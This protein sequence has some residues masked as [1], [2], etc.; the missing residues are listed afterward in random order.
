[1]DATWI[2]DALVGHDTLGVAVDREVRLRLD[3]PEGHL[4]DRVLVPETAG[5]R[6][7]LTDPDA[8]PLRR[9]IRELFGL[10]DEVGGRC[11]LRVLTFSTSTTGFYANIA[12]SRMQV[13]QVPRGN[14]DSLR[15]RDEIGLM[16]RLIGDG[17]GKVRVPA[18]F[19]SVPRT[20]SGAVALDLSP[21]TSAA[22]RVL[23][24]D[25]TPTHTPSVYPPHDAPIEAATSL[26][27]ILLHEGL[28]TVAPLTE[29]D[30]N[31]MAAPIPNTNIEVAWLEE[32]IVD[33]LSSWPGVITATGRSLG[34]AVDEQPH[35]DW[36]QRDH[37]YSVFNATLRA[38]L[39]LGGIDPT[40]PAE[41]RRAV[42]LLRRQPAV[43]VPR[44]LA[45]AIAQ[46]HGLAMSAVEPIESAIWEFGGNPSKTYLV[47]SA[48][49][50]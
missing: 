42:Q 50:K 14:R 1:L 38:L 47:T 28:H 16:S 27:H 15:L 9:S 18:A 31:A 48:L 46:A 24:A 23:A 4:C 40:D 13:G 29:A 2:S 7:F 32:A 41:Y 20:R 8:E 12:A 19:V 10:L 39:Q 49:G 17:T 36:W 43:R 25:P 26:A 33:T 5:A 3:G 35:L 45:R 22:W 37:P 6:T 11:G 44:R 21:N 34:F 30:G